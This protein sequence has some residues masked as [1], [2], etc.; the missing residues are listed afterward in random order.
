MLVC[1][2]VVAQ[3]ERERERLATAVVTVCDGMIGTKRVVGLL[4]RPQNHTV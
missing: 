1:W 4:D 2:L 3:R